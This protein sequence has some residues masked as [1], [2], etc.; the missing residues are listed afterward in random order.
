MEIIG[1]LFSLL[2]LIMFYLSVICVYFAPSIIVMLTKPE[3]LVT[4]I[5]LNTFFGWTCIGWI[6][7]IAGACMPT[8]GKA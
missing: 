2:V 1:E 7:L 4:Y 3:Q 6:L 8:R 5:I